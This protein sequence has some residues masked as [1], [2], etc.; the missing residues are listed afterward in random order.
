[1]V[2]ESGGGCGGDRD[3]VPLKEPKNEESKQDNP[4]ESKL[5]AKKCR[6]RDKNIY[7]IWG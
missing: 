6:L 2:L 3:Y 7:K 5:F 4:W 1:M